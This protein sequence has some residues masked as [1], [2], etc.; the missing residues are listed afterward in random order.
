MEP[1]INEDETEFFWDY[2][3]DQVSD[4]TPDGVIEVIVCQ[5]MRAKEAKRRI[6]KEGIVV[7]DMKGSVIPHP[8]IKIEAEAQKISSSLL[9]K[10]KK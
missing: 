9:M 8:A 3:L 1:K 4:N 10:N 6:D 5:I 2:V 7:R